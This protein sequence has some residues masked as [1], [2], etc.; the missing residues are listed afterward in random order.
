MSIVTDLILITGEYP[1]LDENGNDVTCPSV[2]RLNAHLKQHD[3]HLG[4]LVQCDHMAR[5]WK[6]MQCSM[7]IAAVN[8]LDLD[9]FIE[10]AGSI[11]W[12]FPG[13]VQVFMKEDGDSRFSERIIAHHTSG[14][15]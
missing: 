13:E 9:A 10:Q 4:G 6:S 14:E 1:A 2:E 5:W 3:C 15:D 7:F 12:E 11:P 8:G